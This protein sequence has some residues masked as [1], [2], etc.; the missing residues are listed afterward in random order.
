MEPQLEAAQA[1]AEAAISNGVIGYR[2]I[3]ALCIEALG[4]PLLKAEKTAVTK[5]IHGRHDAASGAAAAPAPDGVSTAAA[6]AQATTLMQASHDDAGSAAG[7]ADAGSAAGA[8]SDC[9]A[10]DP[11]AALTAPDLAD[12]GPE[13]PRVLLFTGFSLNY[14]VGHLCSAAN[15]AY[16]ARHGYGWRCDALPL[17]EMEARTDGAFGSW[18]KVSMINQLL[19][20][21]A[22]RETSRTSDDW[23][24][25][26][27]MW[28]DADAAVIDHSKRVE[29]L[30]TLGGSRA[31]LILAEDM[32]QCCLL[33]AGVLII[34][35]SAWSRALW[36]ELWSA[37]WAKKYRTTP[38]YEQSALLRWLKTHGE[39][40]CAGVDSGEAA[41]HSY[42][43][44]SPV[45][46]T[47][48]LCVV[49]HEMLNTNQ[50]RSSSG[51]E[52]AT[53]ESEEA[54]TGEKMDAADESLSL[55]TLQ[56]DLL[57]HLSKFMAARELGRLACVHSRF[58]RRAG[59]A[60][61]PTEDLSS[62]NVGAAV[63]IRGLNGAAQHNGSI[64]TVLRSLNSKGRHQVHVD[65][66]KRP[67]SVKPLNLADPDALD[68]RLT[69]VELVAKRIVQAHP[70]NG[71]VPRR[72]QESWVRM[73]IELE[74][75]DAPL[76]FTAAGS[77]VYLS[78]PVGT[79]GQ[80]MAMTKGKV[81]LY[82]TAVAGNTVM[83]AGRHAA[84]FHLIKGDYGDEVHTNFA[85]LGVVGPRYDPTALLPRLRQDPS[86]FSV[87]A[88]AHKSTNHTGYDANFGACLNSSGEPQEWGGT[89]DCTIYGQ[90]HLSFP[91]KMQRE[92]RIAPEKRWFCIEKWP[93]ILRFEV[94]RRRWKVTSSVCCW[95]WMKEALLCM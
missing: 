49:S 3:V 4:R 91:L 7:S 41:F 17:E 28:I 85:C 32:T 35:C 67:L 78:H 24:Y 42:R 74:L 73:L 62:Y 60:V 12:S 70:R 90:L 31:Q 29:D 68:A 15:A 87:S 22:E 38:F 26:H 6:A 13:Q 94:E 23:P 66:L 27:L 39:D 59:V 8:G 47:A 69:M 52:A 71:C 93:F 58:G 37:S 20:E 89:A 81:V 16:A 18:Y 55:L 2:Q 25:T 61:S 63:V 51:I 54:R 5:A 11:T 53:G 40:L 64:G 95:I 75:L 14:T 57:H 30:I 1:A 80:A 82:E 21:Q 72:G 36:S 33:N 50:Q 45:K 92:W 65:R 46:Y 76:A 79:V 83:R 84:E 43:G 34:R 56:T 48:H 77:N 19:A 88:P 10:T 44:G 86:W 9:R